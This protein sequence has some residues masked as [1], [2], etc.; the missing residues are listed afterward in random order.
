MPLFVFVSGLLFSTKK[1]W[2]KV[3]YGCMELFSAYCL[4]QGIWM[5]LCGRTSFYSYHEA[6]ALS[7]LVKLC[8]YLYTVIGSVCILNL[9]P[10]KPYLAKYGSRTLTAYLLHFFPIWILQKMSFQSDSL[11]LLTCLSYVITVI[12]IL[13]HQFRIVR[14]LTNPLSLCNRK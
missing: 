4:F 3:L 13:S 14:W 6:L 1:P 12:L 5:I 11:L 10:D 7:P 8:W 9:M 2:D